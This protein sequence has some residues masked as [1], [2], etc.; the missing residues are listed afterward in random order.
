MLFTYSRISHVEI[1]NCD[2]IMLG[3]VKSRGKVMF[4]LMEIRIDVHIYYLACDGKHI[5]AIH[6]NF[7]GEKLK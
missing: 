4:T 3:V 1:R 2:Y 7:Q 6:V 5:F